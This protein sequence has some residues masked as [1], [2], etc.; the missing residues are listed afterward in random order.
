L[1]SV[2]YL[3]WSS[4]RGRPT[5]ASGTTFEDAAF[6]LRTTGQPYEE[7]WP[8]DPYRDEQAAQYEPPAAADQK[9]RFVAEAMPLSELSVTALRRH[10]DLGRVVAIG[11]PTWR[12]LSHPVGGR[13]STPTRAELSGDLHA[14]VTVGYDT[15]TSE[16]LLRNSWGESWGDNGYAWIADQFV[17]QQL[18][19]AWTLS[20]PIDR[21]YLITTV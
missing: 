1:L 3:Y 2:E 12:G 6:A 17:D 11:L 4:R 16:L 15:E 18:V 13:L 14:M 10:L 5:S 9:E 21:D 19:A 20:T 7:A 8:Y